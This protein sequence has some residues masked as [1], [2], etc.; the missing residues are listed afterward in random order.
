M[1][2][3][4]KTKHILGLL[5]EYGLRLW[6]RAHKSRSI[7]SLAVGSA[8]PPQVSCRSWK[9]NCQLNA[10]LAHATRSAEEI[11]CSRAALSKACALPR[12]SIEL[13]LCNLPKN[14]YRLAMLSYRG[15][16]LQRTLLMAEAFCPQTDHHYQLSYIMWKF[17]GFASSSHSSLLTC[18]FPL[19]RMR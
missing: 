8:L 10:E 14:I 17:W 7:N 2:K 5:E 19:S 1:P 4:M 6:P 12:P 18:S 16:L 9:E 3:Y 11:S 13:K 15:S